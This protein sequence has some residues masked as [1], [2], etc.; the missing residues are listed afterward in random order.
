MITPFLIAGYRSFGI[1]VEH[2][3]AHEDDRICVSITCAPEIAYSKQQFGKKRS[4]LKWSR[5]TKSQAFLC[6]GSV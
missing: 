3:S 1:I 4:G 2:F 5:Y 6:S